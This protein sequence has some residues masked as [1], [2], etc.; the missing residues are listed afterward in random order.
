MYIVIA[1]L[2]LEVMIVIHELGH[3]FVGRMMG[4]TVLSFS[5]GFGPKLLSWK[6]G[7]TEYALRLV[8]IGGYCKFLGEDEDEHK[9]GSMLSVKP[10][11]R[12]LTIAAG[13]VAN[14][15]LSVVLMTVFMSING[16]MVPV[17]TKIEAYSLADENGLMTGD[18]IRKINGQDVVAF[19]EVS[20]KLAS[21]GNPTTLTVS[22]GGQVLT[23]SIPRVENNGSSM[24]GIV[25]TTQREP[26]SVFQ[27]AGIGMRWL[28][29]MT[30]SMYQM[31]G[32]LIAGKAA[33]GALVGPVGTI[34]FIAQQAQGG[35]LNIV[36]LVAVLSLNLSVF[37]LIPF[38]ALDGSRLIFLLYEMIRKKPF[39]PNKEGWIHAVGMALLLALMA[40]LTFKDIRNLF[41]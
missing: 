1:I 15:L 12:F 34:G 29:Y 32:N 24:L 5:V 31:L 21:A 11:R 18:V 20:E 28:V 37:N 19:F 9:E 6:R 33:E 27:S 3:F 14:L 22:R 23:M 17:V 41:L 16:N 38:P 7:D 40:F 35:M 2:L 10:W 39:P 36:L 8:P 26:I 30:K 4:I 13:P 25:Y